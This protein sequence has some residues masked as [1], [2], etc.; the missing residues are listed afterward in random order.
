MHADFLSRRANDANPSSEE[1]VTVD[2]MFIE[3]NQCVNASVVAT[4]TNGDPVVSKVLHST[5]HSW[6]GKPE[7]VFKPYYNKRL[8]LTHEDRILWNSRVVAL[9]QLCTLLLQDQC[10]ELLGIIKMK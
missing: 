5:Q 8:N 6:P 4:E 10:A 9:K 3:G 2:V 1:R 7:L